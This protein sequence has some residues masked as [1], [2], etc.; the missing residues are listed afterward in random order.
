MDGNSVPNK[1]SPLPTQREASGVEADQHALVLASSNNSTD[2]KVE[3]PTERTSRDF[4]LFVVHLSH[5]R[6]EAISL[7]L[8]HVWLQGYSGR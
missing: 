7:N 6:I 4:R 1:T 3:T 8:D 2:H 5:R